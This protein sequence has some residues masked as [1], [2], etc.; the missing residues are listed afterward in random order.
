MASKGECADCAVLAKALRESEE[1]FR[2]L[3][4]R[5]ERTE[6]RLC[7]SQKLEAVGQL[8]G[9]IAHDFNNVLSVIL[10]YAHFLLED[11]K[12]HHSL[13]VE[14]EEV[15]RAG[16]RA[17]DLTRQLL[18]FSRQQTPKP[19][20]IDLNETVAGMKN[21][22]TR[23]LSEDVVLVLSRASPRAIIRADCGRIE[24]V[25]LNLVLNARDAMPSGGRLTIT[26]SHLEIAADRE[27]HGLAA[28]SYVAMRVTDTGVGMNEDTRARIFEPFFTT[29][30]KGTGLGLASVSRIVHQAGGT[31]QVDSELGRGTTF[32]LYFPHAG[33][34]AT[35][36]ASA[37][38]PASTALR[39]TET[40][41]VAEDDD[42]LRATAR[43][44]L[45]RCGYTVLDA[46]N[47]GEVLLLCE[48]HP[49]PIHLLLTDVVMPRMNGRQLATRLAPVRPEMKVLYM[50]GYPGD[51]HGHDG[52]IDDG[53]MF[54]PKP[55]FPDALA[56]KVR[57][58]LGG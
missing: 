16:E 3:A 30:G 34:T 19:Q 44:I 35:A 2:L 50:S 48:Q 57:E 1:R 10:S 23:I 45:E 8:A 55:I 29:K 36:T 14:V 51:G 12:L 27:A 38:L 5:L 47:A 26:T 7:Q 18:A 6:E 46:R 43:A 13:R 39:G 49:S 24:Q 41:L 20:A 15:R 9:A 37:V 58:V 21:L 28:G 56:R 31:I 52:G 54:L 42:H 17:T 40:I 4:D 25:I 22:L 53:S 11:L 33:N 32:T